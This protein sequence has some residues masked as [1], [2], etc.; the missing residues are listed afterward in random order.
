MPH[1][2]PDFWEILTDPDALDRFPSTEHPWP[3]STESTHQQE[4]HQERRRALLAAIREIID[5]SLTAQQKHCVI[6]YFYHQRTQNE[7]AQVL[8]ISRRV[9]GQHLFGIQRNGKRIG[10]A[11]NKIRKICERRGLTL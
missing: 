6:L 11:I 2:N 9:V 1:F 8:G 3:Q 4:Q 10:G 7:I 5:T